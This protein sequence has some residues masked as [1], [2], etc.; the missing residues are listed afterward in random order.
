MQLLRIVRL[1]FCYLQA[2]IDKKAQKSLDISDNNC[3]PFLRGQGLHFFKQKCAE[4]S[5][6]D[7]KIRLDA[8]TYLRRILS[9][10]MYCIVLSCIDIYI[11]CVQNI[12]TVLSTIDFLLNKESCLRWTCYSKN[13]MSCT[14][15]V[16]CCWSKNSQ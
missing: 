1:H 3:S 4:L 9:T 8:I 15:Y 10:G 6:P 14:P 12:L 13:P 11:F 2:K 5:I 7:N 16:R